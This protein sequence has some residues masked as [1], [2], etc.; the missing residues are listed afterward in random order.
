MSP[1]RS[2]LLITHDAGGGVEHHLAARCAAIAA[3]G[4]RP[5]LLRPARTAGGDAA[6]S[7]GGV[8]RD[9]YPNLI[10]H[11]PLELRLLTARLRAERP[12]RVELHHLMDHDP[13]VLRLLPALG[14]P[15]EV[16]V[17]DYA[18]FC[19]RVVLVGPQRRYCGEP[20]P[21]VCET[22][23]AEA[24]RVIEE[25]IPV[26]AL[27]DRSARVLGSAER[28]IVPSQDAAARMR[29]HFPGIRARGPCRMS[30]TPPH[31]APATMRRLR[32]RPAAW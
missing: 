19:P 26:Q 14:V 23:L 2:V 29:R 17:H 13:A 3:T 8:A 30:M 6:A 16:H 7:I 24:G 1:R 32:R 5:V 18:W 10:Y 11:L 15:Y 12:K 27:I 28:V 25:D 21:A 4:D 20:A 9:V 22:C 31:C